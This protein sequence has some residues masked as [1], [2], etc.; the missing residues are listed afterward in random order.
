VGGGGGQ[1]AETVGRDRGGERKWER[2]SAQR[3]RERER[4]RERGR[5][6]SRQCDVGSWQLAV[7][8]SRTPLK[9]CQRCSHPREC[10]VSGARTA[11]GVRQEG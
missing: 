9:R 5:G 11:V 6:S 2:D 10:A 4:E 7:C 1:R 8:Q 3:E